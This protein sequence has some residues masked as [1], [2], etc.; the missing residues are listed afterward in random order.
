MNILCSQATAIYIAIAGQNTI[1]IKF[2]YSQRVWFEES[3]TQF[4]FTHTSSHCA[5]D[6]PACE[7]RN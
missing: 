5:T 1:I 2:T 4:P 6:M 3:V 7:Q